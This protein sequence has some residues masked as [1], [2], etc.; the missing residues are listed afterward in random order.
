LI[1]QYQMRL[2]T[3][4]VV[5]ERYELVRLLGEG[6]M[7]S[8][9]AAKHK[10]TRKAVALKFLKDAADAVLLRRFVREARATSAVRHP[11]VVGVHDILQLDGS[12]ALVMDLLEG[13]SLADRLERQGAL[14]VHELASIL[15][16]VLSA[17]TAVH[18]AGIVHRD[19]KPD[20]IFLTRRADGSL[21]PMLL[22]FGICKLRRA[23]VVS[24]ERTQ[25]TGAGQVVG[26]PCYMAPEQ[27]LADDDADARV[28]TW[29]LGVILYECATGKRPFDGDSL[30]RLIKA[31]V[32]A[33]ITPVEQL[34]P[35]LPPEL[36]ALIGR[37]LTRDRSLRDADLREAFRALR[38]HVDPAAPPLALPCIGRDDVPTHATVVR[39]RP[40]AALAWS[41]KTVAH[42][43]R[44]GLATRVELGRVRRPLLLGGFIT[45]SALALLGALRF[46]QRA[47]LVPRASSLH[48]AS[49][50]AP[51][52]MILGRSATK[53]TTAVNDSESVGSDTSAL[54]QRKHAGATWPRR[55]AH[56]SKPSVT[57]F[58][59]RR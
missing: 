57:D 32:T 34:A 7:G 24:G 43:R 41:A 9:W 33:P 54:P 5:A 38:E 40:S 12:L 56:G 44:S 47:P 28:D 39:R 17:V 50:A 4:L 53:E 46:S 23:D 26:T 37:M 42:A 59:G 45:L 35:H 27:I 36:C 48:S 3:G 15:T 11:N 30:P 22:D 14:S 19:L 29:A 16:P 20:N 25:L 21:E 31:I 10:L 8:V 58:G 18:A 52:D 1:T 2:T 51:H 6:S 13:E 55:P 49:P